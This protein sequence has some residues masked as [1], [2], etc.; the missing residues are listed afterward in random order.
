MAKM[1]FKTAQMRTDA[2]EN[3][4]MRTAPFQMEKIITKGTTSPAAF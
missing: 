2:A 1:D 4:Q 3:A